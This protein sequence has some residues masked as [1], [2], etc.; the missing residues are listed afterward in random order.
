MKT[1]GLFIAFGLMSSTGRIIN[2]DTAPIGQLPPGWTVAMTNRGG[3]PHWEIRK[4][5][6]A[7]TQPYVFAQ[8][9]TDPTGNR[10]PLAIF[11]GMSLRDGDVSV[12]IKPV[13]GR[14]DQ[15]GGLVFRYLDANNYYLARTNAL[16][17]NVALYKVENGRGVQ[18]LVSVHHDIQ[19]NEWNILKISARGNKLQVYL[20]HRRLLQAVDNTFK[21]PGKIGLWTM[22]D[23]VTYFDDFRV[24]PK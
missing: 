1:L 14:E 6:S 12:R 2:F 16:E 3:A 17:K 9:S 20:N 21:G 7:P 19:A 13:A 11:D 5:R 24:Y 23:S 4:D 8:V 18:L 22:G 10:F 15:A